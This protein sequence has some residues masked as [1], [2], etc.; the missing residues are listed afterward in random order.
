ML[1]RCR[2]RGAEG[3]EKI[4]YRHAVFEDMEQPENS[5]DMVFFQFMFHEM[6][7]TAMEAALAKAVKMV[8]PGGIVGFA[9]VNPRSAFTPLAF[10]EWTYCVTL[11]IDWHC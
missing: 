3:S 7:S 11:S 4:Q 5:V 2:V 1:P 9:D 6:P 8:R 10:S